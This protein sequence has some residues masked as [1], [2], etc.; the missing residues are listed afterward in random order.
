MATE[1]FK[2]ERLRVYRLAAREDLGEGATEEKIEAAAQ[3]RWKA[4]LECFTSNPFRPL[5]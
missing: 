2:R 5:Q 1:E 4:T 3:K